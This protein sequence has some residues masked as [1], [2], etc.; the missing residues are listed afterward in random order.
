MKFRLKVLSPCKWLNRV[1]Y[2]GKE[3]SYL[4]FKNVLFPK[5]G[6]LK[7]E[8]KYILSLKDRKQVR[9]LRHELRAVG[10]YGDERT[11]PYHIF[12]DS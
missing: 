7:V 3:H 5:W 10:M 6:Y 9:S 2:L 8:V 4:E 12:A 1:K 11:A